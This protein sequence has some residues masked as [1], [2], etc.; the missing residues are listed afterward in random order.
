MKTIVI[1][2]PRSGNNWLQNR[3]ALLYYKC[4]NQYVNRDDIV[5][6]KIVIT[7]AG[8]GGNLSFEDANLHSHIFKKEGLDQIYVLL[9]NPKSIMSSYYFYMKNV[10]IDKTPLLK[11]ILKEENIDSFIKSSYGIERLNKFLSDILKVEKEYNIQYLYY[12]D[13][14]SK[15]FIKKLPIISGIDY[16]LSNN[17][18]DWIDKNSKFTNLKKGIIDKSIPSELREIF[19]RISKDGKSENSR[20]GKKNSYKEDLSKNTQI[21]IDNYMKQ[22]CQLECYRNRYV[23]RN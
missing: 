12:E 23:S 14:F 6:N 3:I 21:Y 10:M 17:E 20:K 4:T 19:C 1:G 9:R 8:Y 18:I 7:H 13:C 2:Y 11:E 5:L 15:D 22:N 16:S